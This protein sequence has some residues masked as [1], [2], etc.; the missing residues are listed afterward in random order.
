VLPAATR[1]SRLNGWDKPQ[2]DTDKRE[3]RN[4]RG[5]QKDQML[6]RSG[7]ELEYSNVRILA[8]IV[9]VARRVV[10]VGVRGVVD[11]GTVRGT[12]IAAVV[13]VHM[14]PTEL[15]A[16]QAQRD[17]ERQWRDGAI[18]G[19]KYTPAC[20]ETGRPGYDDIDGRI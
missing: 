7:A 20:R 6:R 11:M 13:D 8:V 4:A 10:I 18:H 16:E 17:E 19:Q 12:A 5:E 1:D 3:Q 9:R 15:Q 14:Q 2:R